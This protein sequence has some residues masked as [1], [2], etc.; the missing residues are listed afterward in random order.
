MANSK[1]NIQI[2]NRLWMNKKLNNSSH[3]KF[4]KNQQINQGIIY[5]IKQKRP[6][7]APKDKNPPPNS[8]RP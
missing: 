4:L 3:L 8:Q 6:P 7:T 1:R 2:V 5:L